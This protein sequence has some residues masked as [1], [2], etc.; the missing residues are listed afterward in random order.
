MTH[1]LHVC[2]H[3]GDMQTH[4]SRAIPTSPI[5]PSGHGLSCYIMAGGGGV[6]ASKMHGTRSPISGERKRNKRKHSPFCSGRAVT[7]FL[8]EESLQQRRICF[9]LEYLPPPSF[10]VYLTVSGFRIRF[11]AAL[12]SCLGDCGKLK[13]IHGGCWP[14][15]VVP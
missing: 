12:P 9:A 4:L 15:S 6:N 5:S 8:S 3:G 7:L 11:S 13:R 10:Q 14:A 2:S 1:R